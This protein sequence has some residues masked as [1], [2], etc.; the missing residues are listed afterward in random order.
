MVRTEEVAEGM[1]GPI[2]D[3][4]VD[5]ILEAL[6]NV[7]ALMERQAQQQVVA[8]TEAGERRTQKLIEQF[9]KLKPSNFS[10]IGD[11]DE[12]EQWI[13]GMEK[14]F[15]LLNCNGNDRITLA[16]YQLEGN[17]KHWWRASRETVFPVGAAVT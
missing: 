13:D 3:P 12:A 11:P 1:N 6:A 4:R 16:E 10:G 17:A 8:N 15:R 2:S 14:I 5:G 7:G 9:L